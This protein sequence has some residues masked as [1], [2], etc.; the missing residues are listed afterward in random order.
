MDVIIHQDKF[1]RIIFKSYRVDKI[2]NEDQTKRNLL[3][4]YQEFACEK[5]PNEALFSKVLGYFYDAKFKVN[6]STFGTYSLFEYTLSAI[7]PSYIDDEFYTKESL[8]QLFYVYECD[9]LKMFSHRSF[10]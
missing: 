9:F 10:V 6:V 8:E 5:Y 2:I 4:Y 1:H 3:C 7:D